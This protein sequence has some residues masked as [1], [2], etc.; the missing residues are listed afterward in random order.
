[1]VTSLEDDGVGSLRWACEQGGAR[2]VVFNVSG[3]IR[4]KRPLIIRA[5][6]ITIAGQTA[7]VMAF[8]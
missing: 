6:Y 2:M 4:L 3:I 8:V 1:V 5:P 7:L